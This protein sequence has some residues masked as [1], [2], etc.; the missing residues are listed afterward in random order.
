MAY[1][2]L[3]LTFSDGVAEVRFTRPD[4]LNRFDMPAH[5]EFASALEE[6]A[7]R[8]PEIRAL[9]LS[10]E[11]R[12]FSAGGD[13]GEMLEAHAS[14]AIR[15]D[16]VKYAKAVF[17]GVVELHIPVVSAIQ[18]AAIGLGATIATL[19]DIVVAWKGAKIADTHVN[20]GLVAGDGGI[21]SWS[22]SIGVNRAKR[23][24]LTGDIITGEQ[25]FAWGLV[26]ELVENPEDAAPKARELAQ[27][28]A[29]MP[30]AGINGTK[31]AFAR[32]TSML[33]A[34]A[35][36]VGLEYEMQAMASPDLAATV[37]KLRAK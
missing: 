29:A 21:I 6:V 16:M 19:S 35:L 34:Q 11:G 32:I 30:A 9:V 10:A 18:G 31:R 4:L 5:I 36:A 27:R 8:V 24:L 1:Q 22:Q 12:A 26:T 15:A 25:A 2:T 28:I 13:F 3:A 14:Q 23:Y 17:N 37:E 20:V 7:N 33:S